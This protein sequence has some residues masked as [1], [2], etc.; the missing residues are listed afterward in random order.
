MGIA[1]EA[2]PGAALGVPEV[3]LEAVGR[4]G[5]GELVALGVAVRVG[6]GVVVAVGVGVFVATALV[7][8]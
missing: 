5:V 1:F 4:V 6:V 3:A 2:G 7:K 8:V